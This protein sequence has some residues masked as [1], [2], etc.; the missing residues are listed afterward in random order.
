MIAKLYVVPVECLK[1]NLSYLILNTAEKTAIAVDPGEAS[2]FFKTLE[3]LRKKTGTL[4]RIAAAVTTHH[5]Y[6]HVDGLPDFPGVPTWSSVGDQARI[7]AAGTEGPKFPFVKDRT[8]SW[9][10]LTRSGSMGDSAIQIEAFDIPGHT[11]GQIALHVKGIGAES[12]VQESHLFVGDTLFSFGCGRCIEGT[13]EQLFLSLQI[14]KSFPEDTIV[15]FGHEYTK[16][17]VGFWRKALLETPELCSSI[18]NPD[19]LARFERLIESPE[20]RFRSAPTIGEEVASNP[21]LKVKTA[22]EFSEWRAKRNGY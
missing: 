19:D 15:H 17:N 5:H 11:Q 9:S 6:D 12:D 18:V 22:A 20:F 2:P 4:Y 13:P 3:E 21:F 7:P 10:D 8:Y 14:I 16:R 1:D